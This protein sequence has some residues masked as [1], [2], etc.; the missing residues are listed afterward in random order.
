M[1]TRSVSRFR[2]PGATPAD[3]QSRTDD[4]QSRVVIL[5][6]RG[7]GVRPESLVAI[8]GQRTDYRDAALQGLILRV[9]PPDVETKD[10]VRAWCVWVGLHLVPGLAQLLPELAS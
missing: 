2:N 3:P 7:R 6:E 9:S 10:I 4:Q 1:L 5:A 8:N